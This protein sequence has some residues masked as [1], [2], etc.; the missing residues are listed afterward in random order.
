MYVIRPVTAKPISAQMKIC[1][2]VMVRAPAVTPAPNSLAETNQKPTADKT[3]A[4]I[5]PR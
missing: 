5:M 2:P 1:T 3:P 4:T